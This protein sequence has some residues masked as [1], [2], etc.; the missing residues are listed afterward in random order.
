M[1][2]LGLLSI[3]FQ[4]LKDNVAILLRHIKRKQSTDVFPTFRRQLTLLKFESAPTLGNICFI[5]LQ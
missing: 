1:R 4:Q 2:D 3:L 5:C